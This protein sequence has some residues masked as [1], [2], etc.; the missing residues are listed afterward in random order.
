MNTR[1]ITLLAA[2]GLMAAC[3][4]GG[5]GEGAVTFTTWGE[6]FIEEGIPPE[7]GDEEGF[8]DGW[9]VTFDRFLVSLGEIRVG[10]RDGNTAIVSGD[11]RLFDLVRPGP[12]QV[13]RFENVP[14]GSWQE[15]SYA[16]RPADDLQ[17]GNAAAA[18]LELMT[19]NGWSLY[20]E[21]TAVRGG[22]SRTFRW[23][24]DTNTLYTTCGHEDFGTGITVAPGG[25][26]SVEL[27]IHGDHFFFDDLQGNEAELRFDAI[28]A[29]DANDDGEVTLEEL[30][31]VDLDT[32]PEGTYGTGGASGVFDLRDFVTTLARLVGHFRGEGE[33]TPVART[34]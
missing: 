16:I 24:F 3:D 8:V 28:A 21:G 33:C 6:E 19:T 20:V 15:V 27:T 34:Q 7:D 17:I 26:L 14:K 10:N 5:S 29:A 12:V 9:E 25:D 13:E 11:M 23:G 18:D 1:L 32:L 31:Q 22:E 4:N 30:A 2:I